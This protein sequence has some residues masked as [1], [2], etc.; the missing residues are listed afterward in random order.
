[1]SKQCKKI[2]S[3][4]T[5]RSSEAKRFSFAKVGGI[6]EV[7]V[8]AF[9]SFVPDCLPFFSAKI[10]PPSPTPGG[11]ARVDCPRNS[12][13]L[14]SWT[15]EWRP[16]GLCNNEKEDLDWWCEKEQCCSVVVLA[17]FAPFSDFVLFF[18]KNSGNGN[19]PERIT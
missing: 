9:P 13:N 12:P 3:T 11:P 17:P 7:S 19:Q 5:E 1:M 2:A 15:E 18:K 4:K 16:P 6:Y 10:F 14:G 8:T